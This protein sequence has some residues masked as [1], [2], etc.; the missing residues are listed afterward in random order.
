MNFAP[1]DLLTIGLLVL[2]EGLLS[3]DNALVLAILVLALPRDQQRKAL[4]YGILGAFAFRALATFFAAYMIQLSWVK[5]VGALYLLWL[6]LQ[7]FRGGDHEARRAIKPATSWLGLGAFWTTVIKVELTDIVFA[8][9]SILVAVAM[10]PKLWV[11]ITGGL[12]GIVAMR[13]LIGKLLSV[14]Q[15]FPALV[16]GAFVII[17]WVGIKLLIEYLHQLGYL[18]FEVPRWLS[19]GLIVVIFGVFY[20]Y[21]RYQGPVASSESADDAA[22]LLKEPTE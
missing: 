6:P 15:R 7:H 8:I 11:I 22:E 2:L 14:V 21:A 19:L 18:H 10:S 3:A 16:D 20:V 17:A 9:D 5:L 13:L 4:R 12:L 1:T